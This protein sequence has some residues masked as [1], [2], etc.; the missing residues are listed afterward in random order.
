MRKLSLKRH[1][2][3]SK[4]IIRQFQPIQIET[5]L[6]TP[7]DY[8]AEPMTPRYWRQKVKGIDVKNPRDAI[9]TANEKQRLPDA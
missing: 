1:V 3:F 6:F 2:S 8:N 5:N 4:S 9:G 7:A